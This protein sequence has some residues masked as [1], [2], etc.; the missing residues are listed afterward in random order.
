MSESDAGTLLALD[1][2]YA[3]QHDVE[4]AVN[5]AALRFFERSGHSFV[6]EQIGEDGAARAAGF[7]LAQAVWS[8]NRPVVHLMRAVA[9]PQAGT[10]VVGS[11]VRAVVKSAYDAGVYDLFARV[12]STDADLARQLQAESFQSDSHLSFTRVLGSRG[13][14]ATAGAPSGPTEPGDG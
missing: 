14:T 2:S 9:D 12:P 1:D 6:A 4:G 13:A 8:G 5:A 10:E 7:A 3:L 11:L